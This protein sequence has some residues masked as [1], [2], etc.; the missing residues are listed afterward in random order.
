VERILQKLERV[1]EKEFCSQNYCQFSFPLH[2][3]IVLQRCK[4]K[5][6]LNMYQLRLRKYSRSLPLAKTV[7]FS[8]KFVPYLQSL[9]AEISLRQVGRRLGCEFPAFVI[10]VLYIIY[11]VQF[12]IPCQG[13]IYWKIFRSLAP[14][15][16]EFQE[17][18]KGKI[19]VKR[20]Q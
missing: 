4:S 12:C 10:A 11:Y 5:N 2:T 19:K 6:Q 1:K 14:L 8:R 13:C 7:N 18:E 16:G 17:K 3:R 20:V 9:L 15:R